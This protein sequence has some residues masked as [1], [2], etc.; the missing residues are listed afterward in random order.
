MPRNDSV[1]VPVANFVRIT[2]NPVSQVSIAN[3]GQQNLIPNVSFEAAVEIVA[4]NGLIAPANSNGRI[5]MYP[6]AAPRLIVLSS[7]F[8]GVTGGANYLWARALVVPVELFVSH[9]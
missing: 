4:T 7:V 6:G 2:S 9:A 1:P 8:P 3:I 5:V